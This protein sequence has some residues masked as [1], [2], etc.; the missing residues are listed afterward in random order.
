VR[1]EKCRLGLQER[2][3]AGETPHSTLFIRGTLG[4]GTAFRSVVK[5]TLRHVERLEIH[6]ELADVRTTNCLEEKGFSTVRDLL[7]SAPRMLGIANFG[8]KT[9]K[10]S[11][12][13]WRSLASSAPA[14]DSRRWPA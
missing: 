5:K 3:A 7:N 12:S 13:P 14:A 10:K 1:L 6:G 4:A 2:D 8:E 9:W 11:T